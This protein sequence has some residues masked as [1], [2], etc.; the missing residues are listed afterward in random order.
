MCVCFFG[1]SHGIGGAIRKYLENLNDENED[2]NRSAQMPQ[3]EEC[4][5]DHLHG[6][7]SGQSSS[8]LGREDGSFSGLWVTRPFEAEIP[9]YNA[10]GDAH[11]ELVDPS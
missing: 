10:I 11:V 8:Q 4:W 6:S 7:E 1:D 5:V 3:T 2:Y 9:T